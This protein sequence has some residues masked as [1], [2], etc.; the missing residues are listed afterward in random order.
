MNLNLIRTIPRPKYATITILA[1]LSSLNCIVTNNTYDDAIGCLLLANFPVL[2]SQNVFLILITLQVLSIRAAFSLI[3]IRNKAAYI[4]L[5]LLKLVLVESILYCICF[6][7]PFFL[8][9][10][11]IFKDGSPLIGSLVLFGR[12]SLLCL[13]VII[14]VGMFHTKQPQYL[15]ITV[16]IFNLLYHY[17]IEKNFLFMQYSPI[18][19]PIYRIT[20]LT[21]FTV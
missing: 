18:Y 13:L 9:S 8:S 20:H 17:I 4:Q 3:D 11:P 21:Q 14:L 7:I 2:V 12:F 6:Y 16:I 1:L 19:D 15:L 5:T 10:A